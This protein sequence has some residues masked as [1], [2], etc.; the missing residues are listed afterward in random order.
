[1]GGDSTTATDSGQGLAEF[2]TIRA[3]AGVGTQSSARS[4]TDTVSDIDTAARLDND[5]AVRSRPDPRPRTDIEAEQEEEQDEQLLP[6]ALTADDDV[7]DSG[8]ASGR[9]VLENLQNGQ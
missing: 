5:V 1:M 7:F 8:I 6:P 9:E 2:T 3:E 4:D